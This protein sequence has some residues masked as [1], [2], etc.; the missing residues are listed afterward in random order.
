MD[1][2]GTPYHVLSSD[3]ADKGLMGAVKLKSDE[4]I[5]AAY[6][7]E[8]GI[9]A[10][11]TTLETMVHEA[12]ENSLGGPR[13]VV[14]MYSVKLEP[15]EPIE[16]DCSEGLETSGMDTTDAPVRYDGTI[17]VLG[18]HGNILDSL[19]CDGTTNLHGIIVDS[20]KVEPG[21]TR[22][23]A[24][25]DGTE[26]IA[27][28]DVRMEH[29]AR[30]DL[31]C[32]PTAKEDSFSVKVEPNDTE[33][34]AYVDRLQPSVMETTSLSMQHETTTYLLGGPENTKESEIEHTHTTQLP[35]HFRY[36]N[37]YNH[38]LS[39]ALYISKHDALLFISMHAEKKFCAC[40]RT[41]FFSIHASKCM[42]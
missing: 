40:V 14:D 8:L 5:H 30:K 11:E 15:E 24:Y 6:S 34:A 37:F 28:K 32:G 27:R 2:M 26:T 12:T 23:A 16:T 13:S 42:V 25:S 17:N 39:L 19:R 7:E 9:T 38:S 35:A 31:I 1:M 4:T 20:I 10:R 36:N 21:E 3:A 33:E 22:G 29:E 41:F 18:G